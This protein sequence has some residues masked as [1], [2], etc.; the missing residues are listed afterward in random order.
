MLSCRPEGYVLPSVMYILQAA[1]HVIPQLPLARKLHLQC[2]GIIHDS[3]A[4][5]ERWT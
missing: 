5:P 4:W 2:Y 3:V 1:R